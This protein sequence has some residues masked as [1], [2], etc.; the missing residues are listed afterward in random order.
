MGWETLYLFFWYVHF[1]GGCLE[2]LRMFC[3]ILRC[4]VSCQ[5]VT[6]VLWKST[7][8]P[9]VNEATKRFK[10]ILDT[11]IKMSEKLRW[12]L[13]KE[14]TH[15]ITF[16]DNQVWISYGS[17][18]SNVNVLFSQS[19]WSNLRNENGILKTFMSSTLVLQSQ[20]HNFALGT[21]GSWEIPLQRQLQWNK[22]DSNA[23][24]ITCYY[25]KHKIEKYANGDCWRSLSTC[26]PL[27]LPRFQH[28]LTLK[29]Y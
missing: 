14:V 10:K 15:N 23:F 21:L 3:H 20:P 28:V 17:L 7:A 22:G 8:Q 16:L 9:N 12:Y 29:I 27:Q 2:T 19:K 24:V 1:L 6:N 18:A 13:S 26:H 4:N 5:S 25:T 11:S